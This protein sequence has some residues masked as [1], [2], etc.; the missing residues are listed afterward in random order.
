ME[1]GPAMEKGR[2][3]LSD[4]RPFLLSISSFEKL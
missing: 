4:F 3:P 2:K 1:K